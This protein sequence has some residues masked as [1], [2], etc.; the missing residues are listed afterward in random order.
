MGREWGI[1]G[2]PP[3]GEH[4]DGGRRRSGKAPQN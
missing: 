4:L 2:L 3:P 1:D